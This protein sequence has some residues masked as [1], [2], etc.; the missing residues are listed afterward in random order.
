MYEKASQA[1]TQE[2]YK[3]EAEFLSNPKNSIQGR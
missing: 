1:H 3:N 2:T